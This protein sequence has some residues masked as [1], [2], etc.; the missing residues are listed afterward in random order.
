MSK[1]GPPPGIIPGGANYTYQV[2][3][4][5]KNNSCKGN[6]LCNTANLTPPLGQPAQKAYKDF[7]TGWPADSWSI[8]EPALYYQA[9][10]IRLLANFVN[11]AGNN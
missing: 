10:Y 3:D 8:S 7:N 5:C 4:C 1:Y 9:A 6:I 2:D 11:V